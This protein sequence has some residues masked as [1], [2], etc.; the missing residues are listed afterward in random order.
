MLKKHETKSQYRGMSLNTLVMPKRQ[1][2]ATTHF[3]NHQ[4]WA[5]NSLVQQNAR[6]NALVHYSDY[7]NN[8]KSN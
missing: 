5:I 6:S 7:N 3:N 1:L 4:K 2:L 8:S